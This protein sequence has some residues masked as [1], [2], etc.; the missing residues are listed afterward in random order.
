MTV[1]VQFGSLKHDKFQAGRRGANVA[2]G[3]VLLICETEEGESKEGFVGC[4][5]VGCSGPKDDS[6]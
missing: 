2:E 5:V 3:L 6:D 4:K 1:D